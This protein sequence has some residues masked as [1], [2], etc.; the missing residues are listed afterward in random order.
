MSPHSETDTLLSWPQ[1]VGR[2]SAL[3][4][5]ARPRRR[6]REDFGAPR[7]AGSTTGS[8]GHGHSRRAPPYD[9]TFRP[10]SAFLYH[11]PPLR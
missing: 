10:N 3:A 7:R 8:M 5:G 11:P 1:S 9:L 6:E 2:P 4:T